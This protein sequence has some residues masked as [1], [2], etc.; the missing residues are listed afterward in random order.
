[1]NPLALKKNHNATIIKKWSANWKIAPRGIKMAILDN[2]TPSSN[3]L[4]IISHNK[5]LHKDSSTLTQICTGHFPLNSYLYKFK[6]VD[7]PRCPA[8]GAALETTH[9]FLFMCLSY[10][11][12]RWPLQ[13]NC[14]GALMLKKLLSD[15]KLTTSLLTYIQTTERFDKQSEFTH[16]EQ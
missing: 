14:K 9:H 2:I 3:F 10:A 4:N 13:Q 1:M 16:P 15:R 11:H 12:E 7:S 6:L 5:L 8:C